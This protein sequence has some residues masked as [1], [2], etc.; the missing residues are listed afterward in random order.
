[1]S[2]CLLLTLFLL[3]EM[4]SGDERLLEIKDGVDDVE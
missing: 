4:E 1:M 3:F 2:T